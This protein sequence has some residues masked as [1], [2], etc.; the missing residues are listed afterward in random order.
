[1]LRWVFGLEKGKGGPLLVRGLTG[2]VTAP[3]ADKPGFFVLEAAYTDGGHAP[4]G[5]LSGKAQVK[6][7]SRRVEAE[8]GERDLEKG[9]KELGLGGA[10]GNKGLGAINDGHT[11]KFAGLN[12]ADSKTVTVRWASGGVGG[13]IELRAGSA[14]GALLASSE[15]PVTGGWDKWQEATVPLANAPQA[16]DV[17][18][19]FVNPGKGGLMNLDWVQFNP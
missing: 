11:V 13:K 14:S 5:Q 7:R 6:L 2:E 8:S 1:M 10:S 4:A 16:C 15:A 3:K 17:V 9:P 18:V 19:V 12:L